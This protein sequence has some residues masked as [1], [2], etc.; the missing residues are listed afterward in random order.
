M[1]LEDIL[2]SIEKIEKYTHGLTLEQFEQNT[3]SQDAVIR[4]LEI[5]GEAVK[6][7]PVEIREQY[8]AISWKQIAGMRDVLIHEYANV[9]LVRVWNV[10]GPTQSS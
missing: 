2:E 4:R 8:P 6:G 5:L 3:E 1:Y 10:I 9:S 7:V